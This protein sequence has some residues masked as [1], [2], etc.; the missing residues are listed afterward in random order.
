MFLSILIAV[1]P[2]IALLV[3]FYLKIDQGEKEPLLNLGLALAIGTG[4]AFLAYY[5]QSIIDPFIYENILDGVAPFIQSFL[6]V[7]LV[8]EGLKW[9]PLYFIFRKVGKW[10]EYSDAV[11]SAICIGMGFALVEN[12][13]YGI[14]GGISVSILRAFTA[15]PAHAIYAVLMG[16]FMSRYFFEK[17]GIFL[18]MS[19]F[20]PFFLHGLYDFFILQHF[21][22][23]LMLLAFVVLIV[24]LILALHLLKQTKVG[25]SNVQVK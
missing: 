18:F 9:L 14:S 4:I 5:L 15:V 6:G 24:C 21:A 8:E 12:I 7:S 22:E 10:N 19:F 16:F 23:W 1:I 17:K 25:D 20:L 13:I 3:L 2:V 11:M